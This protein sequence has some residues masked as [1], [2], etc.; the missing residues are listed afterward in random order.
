MQLPG[1]WLLLG[2][3]SAAYVAMALK[4]VER[5]HRLEGIRPPAAWV[6]LREASL[7]A[8]AFASE[9]AKVRSADVRAESSQFGS[10]NRVG[11]G[12]V[13]E[14]LGCSEQWAR[15]RLRRGDFVTARRVGRIWLVDE[16][17][18]IAWT[19]SQAACSEAAA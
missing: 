4:W 13:A 10:E 15:N 7:R 9:S 6:H 3:A 19:V 8:S 18:L 2:P 16:D 12:R 17:E 1:G 11:A 5:Q 14:V